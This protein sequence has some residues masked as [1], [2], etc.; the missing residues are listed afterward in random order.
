MQDRPYGLRF[1]IYERIH[2]TEEAA[3]IAELEEI[4]LLPRIQVVEQEDQAALRGHLLLE[5]VYRGEEN[6]L[7]SLTH[8]IPVEITIPMNRVSSVEDISVEIENFD[9]DLLSLRSLNITG[10]LSLHGV[11]GIEPAD[12]SVW[13]EDEF[14]VVHTPQ[15][16]T[17]LVQQREEVQEQQSEPDSAFVASSTTA[18]EQWNPHFGDSAAHSSSSSDKPAAEQSSNKPQVWQFESASHAR[19]EIREPD[20]PSGTS[21]AN[22]DADH[23]PWNEEREQQVDVDERDPSSD[24]QLEDSD[25]AV[26]ALSESELQ[27]EQEEV[28]AAVDSSS[29][30]KKEMKVAFGSKKDV[31]VTELESV[32][33]STLLPTSR[34]SKEPPANEA[35]EA[36]AHAEQEPEDFTAAGGRWNSLFQR[37]E[38]E[39]GAFRKLR[40]C[41]VQREETLET[42]A[43]RYEL[44]VR[45][46]QLYNRLT[47][48]GVEEGQVL[49]IP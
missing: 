40:L 16:P 44:S 31:L 8:L 35:T 36:E 46:L 32:P 28:T 37:S 26:S 4:E 21:Q 5:G 2:L 9:V 1:D 7:Q 42:I 41:I 22:T 17:N 15:P 25:A 43:D 30:D 34:V 49:L 11:E 39:Q 45:E 38:E 24:I 29:E 23:S 48:H 47:E 27:N 19:E 18:P 10:V 20:R 6:E 33:F 3:G 12:S 14:T 13:A